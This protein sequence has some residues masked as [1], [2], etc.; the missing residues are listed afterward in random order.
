MS[1]GL[2]ASRRAR[3]PAVTLVPP[4]HLV[5]QLDALSISVGFTRRLAPYYSHTRQ[6]DE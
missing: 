6:Q 4:D 2:A 1:L 5:R 3:A